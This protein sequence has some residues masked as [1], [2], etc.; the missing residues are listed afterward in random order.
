MW[1]TSRCLR[2]I[3]SSTPP[4]SEPFLNY[5]RYDQPLSAQVTPTVKIDSWKAPSLWTKNKH[6]QGREF[7]EMDQVWHLC[8]TQVIKT[9]LAALA[10]A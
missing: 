2:V 4:T 5:L 6:Q 9:E 1:V 10:V 7:P 8:S 3:R